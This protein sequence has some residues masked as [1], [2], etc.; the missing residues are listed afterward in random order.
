MQRKKGKD[1]IGW[2]TKSYQRECI[3]GLCHD[4][5]TP[6]NY[7]IFFLNET[8]Q[9]SQAYTNLSTQKYVKDTQ[10]TTKFIHIALDLTYT[11]NFFT[12]Q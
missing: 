6:Y 11:K 10:T 8:L 3:H 2:V 7:H 4:T 5:G 12:F 1:V 9:L